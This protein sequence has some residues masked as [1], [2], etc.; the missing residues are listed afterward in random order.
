MTTGNSAHFEVNGAG[1]RD[2]LLYRRLVESVVDYAIFMLDARG[3]VVT[4]N[5]GA[6]RIKG[7]R[8]EDI[9]GKHFSV[10][11]TPED[12]ERGKPAWELEVATRE[13]RVEDEA[14]RVRKD[15]S[16][17]W[18]NVVITALHDDSGA[19]TGF[20]KV[21]RD[22]SERRAAEQRAIADAKLVAESEAANRAKSEF[23][24]I[25][26]HELR[27][28]LNAI[29]GYTQLLR[30]GIH[31][32]V[33]E[34]QTAV[35]E[36]IE[37]S[38][39][40]LLAL[41]ND[42]LNLSRIEAGRVE[43]L[44]EDVSLAALI[45]EILPLI[46]PQISA[47]GLDCSVCIAPDI[48]IRADREK[49]QQ[50][51]LNLLSNAVKFTAPP[52]RISITSAVE[53]RNPGVVHVRVEDTGIGIPREKLEAVFDP[54]VQVDSSRTRTSEGSGLGL[55]ISRDLALGMNGGLRARSV[56]GKGSTFTVTLPL[57]APGGLQGKGAR[58]KASASRR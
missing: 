20:A 55:A 22:L 18:A 38:N 23:L 1:Q 35:L 11:Y 45:D 14:W 9:I 34:Q 42:I 26:S 39:R 6:E 44:I 17:F 3:R 47:K 5:E 33:N 36:R 48:T 43:Y 58:P 28:P 46:E 49:V 56:E 32:L 21:T 29:A 53:E 27:T 37:R 16:L 54:F 57:A 2:D 24:A 13:G 40:H 25:M 31:G 4:W 41:I 12:L 15:G 7:Y 51:M 30:M 50:I 10:F 8:S 52:G 19:L